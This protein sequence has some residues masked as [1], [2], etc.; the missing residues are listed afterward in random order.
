MLPALREGIMRRSHRLFLIGVVVTGGACATYLVLRRQTAPSSI[1]QV[2]GLVQKTDSVDVSVVEPLGVSPITARDAGIIHRLEQGLPIETNSRRAVKE[3]LAKEDVPTLVRNTG[4]IWGA[5]EAAPG[6]IYPNYE[7]VAW[8][9]H[10]LPSNLRVKQIIQEARRDPNRVGKLVVDDLLARTSQWKETR[11]QY[12][13]EV[14]RGGGGFVMDEKGLP[15][16]STIGRKYSEDQYA[17]PAHVFILANIDYPDASTAVSAFA[18]QALGPPSNGFQTLKSTGFDR[19]NLDLLVFYAAVKLS[20]EKVPE[21]TEVANW[22]TSTFGKKL[23]FYESMVDAPQALWGDSNP[24]VIA[25]QIDISKEPRMK[26]ILPDV[27]AIEELPQHR[28]LFLYSI[29]AARK[30]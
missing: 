10:A 22:L 27:K 13:E 4:G 9:S 12:K 6:G 26:L 8:L 16:G 7:S 18:K 23:P 30:G 14:A 21:N 25:G 24:L 11:H 15:T 28:K 29:L 5:L 1:R 20:D 19:V 17:M 2:V 3:Q